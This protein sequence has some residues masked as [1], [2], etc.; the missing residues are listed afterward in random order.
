MAQPTQYFKRSS[1]GLSLVELMVVMAIGTVLSLLAV[2]VFNS[3]MTTMRLN[4]VASNVSAAIGKTRYR[5]IMNSQP[6]TLTLSTP[7]NTYVVTN[8]QSKVTD[9][10]VP[11]PSTLVAINGGGNATYTFTF[12][13][14][15]TAYGAGGTCPSANVTP[16][17]SLTYKSRQ[18][19]ISVSSVG[20]VTT[21]AI[22]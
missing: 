16:V 4:A 21:N 18:T 13:P 8:L 10:A 1:A 2:P 3:A 15:G 22:H 14:N 5:A 12:C 9:N 20:N 19:D 6:Y 7:G 17:L 11:L